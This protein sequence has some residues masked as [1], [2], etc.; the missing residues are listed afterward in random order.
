VNRARADAGRAIAAPTVGPPASARVRRMSS[1]AAAIAAIVAL[2]LLLS[3][4]IGGTT[5]AGRSEPVLVAIYVSIL[6]GSITLPLPRPHASEAGRRSW[7]VGAVGVGAVAAATL[8]AGP[9][10]PRALVAS[11]L[12][13]NLLAAVSEEALFRRLVY[14]VL[15]PFGA[16][17]AIGVAAVAFALVHLPLYGVASLPVDL[18]AGLLFSWQR[19]ASGSWG[20]PA[21][22]HAVANVLAS[23]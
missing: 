8:L 19:W 10:A 4:S 21:V 11:A 18:G 2:A 9:A 16:P 23:M 13:L 14:G 15:E 1:I 3:R 20:A 12:P 6:L 5:I 22:A 7:W 17:V